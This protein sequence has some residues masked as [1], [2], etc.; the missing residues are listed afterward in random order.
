MERNHGDV[1]AM[2]GGRYLGT[3]GTFISARLAHIEQ[4]LINHGK[5]W[6]NHALNMAKTWSMSM[7]ASMTMTMLVQCVVNAGE[8]SGN[9]TPR[10]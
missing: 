6:S 5:S 2:A 7:V 1:G 4:T 9:K 10:A 8:A 3:I